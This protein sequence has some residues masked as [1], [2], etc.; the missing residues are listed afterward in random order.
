M[1]HK[2]KGKQEVDAGE[3]DADAGEQEAD[4]GE[5]EA[6]AHEQEA[7]ARKKEADARKK[8]AD[9]RKKEADTREQEAECYRNFRTMF[10]PRALLSPNFQ[11]FT[12]IRSVLLFWIFTNSLL[13]SAMTSGAFNLNVVTPGTNTVPIYMTFLLYSMLLLSCKSSYRLH[14]L[15]HVYKK[16]QW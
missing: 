3:Q 16:K 10:V 13:A 6:D 9:T 15:R 12:Q 7:D 14:S 1:E 8:E 2:S 11:V 4:A 5:Q